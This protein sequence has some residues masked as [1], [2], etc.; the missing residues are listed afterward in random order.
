[1]SSS[2][3]INRFL[4][5]DTIVPGYTNPQNLNRYRYVTNNPLRYTD[6][7]GHMQCEDYQGS[8][9]SEDQVTNA[10]QTTRAK[11]K[12]ANKIRSKYKNIN[13]K[14][15]NAWRLEDLNELD[16]GLF[17]I[18]GI[19]GFDGN[20]NAITAAFGDVTF[21]PVILGSLGYDENTGM[22]IPANA[23]WWD[24]IINIAPNATSGT[25][26]HEMG[27][28]L[29]G[30]LKRNDKNMSL[31]SNVNAAIFDSGDGATPYGK[32]NSMEDFADS[33]LAVIKYGTFNNPAIDTD[34]VTAI[35]AL[36]QSY[37]NIP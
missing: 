19:R 2:P 13:I 5:A 10:Y 21:N 12:V 35:T 1:M 7:T 23:A 18:N 11:L 32:T 36:I 15:P 33:F 34:R 14:S 22:P 3:Y 27:H 17:L 8:C 29:D 4:S 24:G 37:T 9:A 26:I 6:P 16:Y 20:T 31:R 30:N 25:V 28:I